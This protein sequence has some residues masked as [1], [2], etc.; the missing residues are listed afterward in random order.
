[1]PAPFRPLARFRVLVRARPRVPAR[2]CLSLDFA[3][4]P[5]RLRLMGLPV[6]RPVRPARPAGVRRPSGFPV[7]GRWC[8]RPGVRVV[9][10]SW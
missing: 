3:D 9:R 5:R 10:A 4:A 1:M 8:P 2:D 7:P 6:S